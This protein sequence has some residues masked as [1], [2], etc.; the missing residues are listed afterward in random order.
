[1][2]HEQHGA[3]PLATA[4]YRAED[5]DPPTHPRIQAQQIMIPAQINDEYK[6]DLNPDNPLG[7]KVIIAERT[8]RSGILNELYP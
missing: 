3:V 5:G 7:M 4:S 1:M 8:V 6:E 2:L